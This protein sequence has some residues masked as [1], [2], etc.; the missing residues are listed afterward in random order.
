MDLMTRCPHCAHTFEVSL[1]QLQLRK[2]F[3]RCA[4]C[5]HI[6][7]GY[8]A[9]VPEEDAP[10]AAP[11]DEPAPEAGVAAP[12]EEPILPSVV[13][14]RI[15]D[16]R[17]GTEPG[18]DFTVSLPAGNASLSPEPRFSLRERD[19]FHEAGR[20]HFV[21]GRAEDDDAEQDDGESE[22]GDD[23]REDRD[24]RA[25]YLE[26]RADSGRR[27]R[28]PAFLDE[29][30][31]FSR[32]L[33]RVVWRILAVMAILCALLLLVY[34]Y[35]VQ[36]ANSAPVLRPVLEKAC[37]TLK[38]RIPF[39]RQIDQVQITRSSLKAGAAVAGEAAGPGQEPGTLILEVSLR[40]SY[41]RPQE[42]PVLML[43]LTDFS[44]ATVVRRELPPDAYL[45][46]DVAQQPFAASSEVLVRLPII[47]KNVNVNGYKLSKYFP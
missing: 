3:V 5:S 47:P 28:A 8:E 35:R 39:A 9:V 46:P 31:G 7:D 11:N 25:L 20:E 38:C 15:S 13:R 44:G 4:R 30:I 22:L 21:F 29:K 24:E 2:G 14:H 33:M 19:A 23:T 18:G 26:P 45:S 32:R 42:W 37:S 36:I 43:D 16:A 17:A 41:D 12:P 6:F 27:A 10:A 34:V 1:A 40:N